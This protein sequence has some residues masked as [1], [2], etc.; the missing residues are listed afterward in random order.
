MKKRIHINK[1]VIAGNKKHGRND[2]PITVKTYK[3]N[4]K[5]HRVEIDGPSVL[6]HSPDKPLNCGAVVWIETESPVLMT[7]F[8]DNK[9]S[10][11]LS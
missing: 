11:V 4:D 6:V 7:G 2:P 9:R 8:S 1:H 3:S 5:C 10:K